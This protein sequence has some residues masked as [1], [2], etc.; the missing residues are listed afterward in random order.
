MFWIKIGLIF[1]K[2]KIAEEKNTGKFKNLQ[3]NKQFIIDLRCH[4]HHV[5]NIDTKLL[6]Y[7]IK[8]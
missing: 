5:L 3:N 6:V 8:S 7:Q 1:K 2:I 4:T